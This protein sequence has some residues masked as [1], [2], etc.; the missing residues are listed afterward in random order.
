MDNYKSTRT[1][2]SYQVSAIVSTYNSEEFIEGC[3]QDLLAQTL[4]KKDELEIVII[5]S[6]S[7]QNEKK[8]VEQYQNIYPHIVYKRTNERETLYAAWNR[9]IIISS[10][11]YITNANTDDRH[12]K[13]ALEIMYRYLEK[14]NSIA[15]IY[16]DQLISTRKNETFLNNTATHRWNW[17]EF[18]Y[19]ELERRCIIGSQPM[20]RK[21]I[22]SKYGLFI[23]KLASAGDYE[24]WLR[25]LKHENALR[26]NKVLGIYYENPDGLEKGYENSEFEIKAIRQAYGL[27]KRG[28]CCTS[29]KKFN[30]LLRIPCVDNCN[31]Q[32]S[33]NIISKNL[34]SII[35]I[36]QE[37][38]EIIKEALQSS[39]LQSDRNIEIIIVTNEFKNNQI[40]VCQE[41]IF[42]NSDV[43]ILLVTSDFT[44]IIQAAEIG[45]KCS[46]GEFLIFIDGRT[47]IH[48]NLTC[49]CKKILQEMP[50]KNTVFSNYLFI[51]SKTEKYIT[52]SN[53]KKVYSNFTWPPAFFR[54]NILSNWIEITT[55]LT[56]K[57]KENSL[58]DL[59]INSG[60][61]SYRI[62][63]VMIF[64]YQDN[65]ENNKKNNTKMIIQKFKVV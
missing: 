29:S 53:N 31:I 44:N 17:P 19:Q 22:H 13:D 51:D 46:N 15:L 38:N 30:Y 10:G 6:A 47:K 43:N 16:A 7:E 24:F 49:R 23:E 4:Y 8:I 20:W 54:R 26:I 65:I 58:K 35:I 39:I 60:N 45:I 25:I 37:H 40:H 52:P 18:S 42:D 28:I 14:D 48:P 11:K 55:K 36:D 12:R 63:E 41:F 57:G 1:K 21:S 3:L 32:N 62:N 34:T 64:Y 56:I 27:D 61:N 33:Y 2:D 50:E 9:A 59:L 5:D